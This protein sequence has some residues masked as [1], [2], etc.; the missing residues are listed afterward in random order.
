[1]R[2]IQHRSAGRL[3]TAAVLLLALLIPSALAWFGQGGGNED[4]LPRAESFLLVTYRNVEARG[5]LLGSDPK[6]ATLT[7]QITRH[8]ARGKLVQE[9]PGSIRFTYMPYKNK[10][11][12][13]SFSYVE[14]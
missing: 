6:G 7:F 5:R 10:T 11:G 13:D 3:L 4:D 2:P 1:M 12:R 8:P 14:M 9:S